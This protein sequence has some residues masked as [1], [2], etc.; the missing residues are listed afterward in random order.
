MY[1]EDGFEIPEE[2]WPLATDKD[3]YMSLSLKE[4][5]TYITL[6][7]I[8]N[9]SQAAKLF[10]LECHKKHF[11]YKSMLKPLIVQS[12]FYNKENNS[13]ELN[14]GYYFDRQKCTIKKVKNE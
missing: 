7:D 9:K 6:R 12:C 2:Y 11:K 10:K 1:D 13:I 14:K 3:C 5:N 8:K 4:Y